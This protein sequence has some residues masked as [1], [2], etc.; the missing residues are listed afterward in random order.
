VTL[1]F[2]FAVDDARLRDIYPTAA[3]GVDLLKAEGA[4]VQTVPTARVLC[5]QEPN[6]ASR[7]TLVRKKDPL[8]MPR[9]ELDWR[10]TRDDRTSMLRTL[11]VVG[12]QIGQRGVGRLQVD[13]DGF[14]DVDPSTTTKLD[15][16]VNT[17]SHHLGTARMSTTPQQGVVDPDCKVH[18]VANLY[19]AGSAVFPTS[20]AN[21]PTLTIV[22]LALRLG[23]HLATV[24]PGTAP[25]PPPPAAEP[26]AEPESESVP[27]PEPDPVPAESDAPLP[28]PVEGA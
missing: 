12:Q 23:A 24:V 15:Y 9:I 5:E 6:L 26:E 11:R 3:R 25:P 13:I 7:V 27:A 17:G 14:V 22:A 10:L 2:P 8:G 19:V 16:P 21:T 4:L 20:G 1:E 28:E 18:S